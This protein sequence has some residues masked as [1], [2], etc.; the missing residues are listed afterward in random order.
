MEMKKIL[1][2]LFSFCFF[3]Q[4]SG[5]KI[6]NEQ[7]KFYEFGIVQYMYDGSNG[8]FTSCGAV[9][10]APSKENQSER[11]YTDENGKQVV[12][13]NFAGCINHFMY[14]GWTIMDINYSE[15]SFLVRREITKEEA[16]AL[17]ERCIKKVK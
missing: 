5:Q 8:K 2:F 15:N 13:Y 6:Y 11:Y 3:L 9:F 7:G 17:A 4:V 16:D 12:F 14:K 10:L 1:L